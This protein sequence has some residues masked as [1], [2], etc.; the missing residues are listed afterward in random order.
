MTVPMAMLALLD[1]GPTHGFDLKRRY[2]AL[3]GHGRELKAGQVYSTLQRLERDGLTAGVGVEA[4]AG[5]D[6]KLYAITEAG[7]T[8]FDQWLATPEAPSGRPA[9]IFT[10]VVLALAS[11]RNAAAVLEAHQRAY[12]RRMRALT[13]GRKTG[14]VID[15]LAGD[16]EIEH[17][18]ADL[19]WIEIAAAR[20]GDM[21]NW[22]HANDLREATTHAPT[23]TP[24]RPAKNGTLR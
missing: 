18:Q 15:R 14:D 1:E 19:R 6:R 16:Y 13:A 11:G 17:L 7:I 24:A 5:A 10:R 8:E 4:G 9:E 20:L 3:L 2:D 22:V 21:S 12:L 23:Q